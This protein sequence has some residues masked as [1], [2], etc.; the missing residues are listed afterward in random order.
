MRSPVPQG[1]R[2]VGTDPESRARLLEWRL[3]LRVT[4]SKV[5]HGHCRPTL[6]VQTPIGKTCA[7][8]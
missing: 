2:I 6:V 4:L 1:A 8:P 3:A 5:S 7:P